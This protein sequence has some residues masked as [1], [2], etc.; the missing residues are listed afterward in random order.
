MLAEAPAGTDLTATVGAE[1]HEPE[2]IGTEQRVPRKMGSTPSISWRRGGHVGDVGTQRLSG[3]AAEKARSMR[4]GARGRSSFLVVRQN[5]D[6]VN[7]SEFPH[8]RLR[9]VPGRFTAPGRHERLRHEGSRVDRRAYAGVPQDSQN[10]PP[11]SSSAEQFAQRWG[12]GGDVVGAG[13]G[14]GAEAEAGAAWN[15]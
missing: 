2:T 10:L 11:G 3:S 1:S 8:Q 12:W 5:L 13:A 4:S 9:G 15:A 6:P 7:Q 14:T